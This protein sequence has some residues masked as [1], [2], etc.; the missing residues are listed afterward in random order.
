[1]PVADACAAGC[2]GRL[3]TCCDTVAVCICQLATFTALIIAAP[4][5]SERMLCVTA[6]RCIGIYPLVQVD[7]FAL[8]G[9]L[10]PQRAVA[11]YRPDLLLY[12]PRALRQ[13]HPQQL[14]R[15]RVDK[16]ADDALGRMAAFNDRDAVT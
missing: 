10:V 1:L 5:R 12:M 6:G 3:S 9:C 7:P 14:R 13:A 4:R 11:G 16:G 2:L 8:A 15:K